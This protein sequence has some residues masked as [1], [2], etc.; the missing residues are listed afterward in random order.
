[1]VGFPLLA[2]DLS[3]CTE[4]MRR[5][6]FLL[7]DVLG[8]Y[9][10]SVMS[11]GNKKALEPGVHVVLSFISSGIYG[12]CP[13]TVPISIIP[14]LCSISWMRGTEVNQWSVV[15]FLLELW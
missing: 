4:D 15:T 1:M 3:P 7:E 10:T 6:I 9:D 13:L 2:K 11:I 12:L 14:Q 8:T 5:T